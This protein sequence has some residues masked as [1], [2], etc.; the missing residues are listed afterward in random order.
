MYVAVAISSAGALGAALATTD[1]PALAAPALPRTPRRVTAAILLACAAVLVFL[2]VGQS[3]AYVVTGTLP[4]LILDAGSATSPHIVAALDLTTIVPPLVLGA[5]WLWKQRPWGYVVSAAMAVQGLLI[6]VDL[7]STAPSQAAAG[8]VGAWPMV[9]LWL[10]M[11]AAFLAASV[12]LLRG[13]RRRR[14]G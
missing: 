1:A 6:T 13:P 3:V 5:I 11:A 7:V 10:A 8:V 2:W 12:L 4:Q 14:A 9:P